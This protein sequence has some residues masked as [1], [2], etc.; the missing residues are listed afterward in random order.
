[1]PWFDSY[2]SVFDKLIVIV[3]LGSLEEDFR[4]FGQI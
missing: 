4:R 1:M 2:L 3:S